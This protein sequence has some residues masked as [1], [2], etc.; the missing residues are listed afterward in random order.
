MKSADKASI[1]QN[2]EKFHLELKQ[3]RQSSVN[4]RTK[5]DEIDG[6]NQ[7]SAKF[8]ASKQLELIHWSSKAY[9]WNG[10]CSKQNSQVRYHFNRFRNKEPSSSACSF[11]WENWI[12]KI[13]EQE[14]IQKV[15][16]LNQIEVE[17]L[18]KSIETLREQLDKAD[19]EGK[20]CSTSHAMRMMR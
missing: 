10:R 14:N 7:S 18:K 12:H 15:K 19:A 20:C 16:Q 13:K 1:Q 2:T 11:P 3:L 4:L 5:L 17:N 6:R 9:D 8:H